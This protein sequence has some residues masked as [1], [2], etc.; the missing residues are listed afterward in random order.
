[1]T[2]AEADVS[3]GRITYRERGSGDPI[4]FV[5]GALVNG[6]LWRDVV[7]LLSEE[8][9]CILPDLPLGSHARPMEPTADLSPPG[10]ATIVREFIETLDLGSAVVVAND[11]G[12][13]IAQL[14][15]VAHPACVDRLVLT[16]CDAFENFLPRRFRYLQYGARVPGFVR[17][18][19]RL[20]QSR[21]IARGPLGYGPLSITGI[22]DDLLEA[23]VSP[24]AADPGVRRDLRAVL[25]G[26]SARYTAE[27]AESFPDVEVPVLLAW[28]TADALFPL[29]HARRLEGLF[30][31][32][33]L[34]EIDRSGAFVPLDRPDV[35]ADAVMTFLVD[36][37]GR[38]AE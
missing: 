20:M 3:A 35:L 28:G 7:P 25:R 6:Q 29:E 2:A 31:T 33:R 12:G 9:R 11:T 16:N 17:V 27:A 1:M 21:R 26:I 14:L 36:P 23:F 34:A 8:F 15:A 37:P 4:V 10:L 32:A 19:S 24:V 13:A 18:L 5:H 22:P 38:P 30:P